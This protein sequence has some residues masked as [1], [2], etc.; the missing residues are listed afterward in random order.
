MPEATQPP[1]ATPV[2]PSRARER[3]VKGRGASTRGVAAQP[4]CLR[5]R[6]REPS[7]DASR[8]VDRRIASRR[9]PIASPPST[10]REPA[11]TAPRTYDQRIAG[12]RSTQRGPAIDAAQAGDQH[13]MSSPIDAPRAHDQHIASPRSAH[14]KPAM[15]GA[16]NA[17][18][19]VRTLHGVRPTQ[20]NARPAETAP[21]ARVCHPRLAPR[22]TGTA[23]TPVAD[24]AGGRTPETPLWSARRVPW[25]RGPG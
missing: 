3:S 11:I 19:G 9:S 1:S 20:K 17:G 4:Q 10:H 21:D 16:H 13:I 5:S 7:I 22:T 6:H 8:A 15:S 25:M 14:R 23:T 18:A 24:T 2:A 12:P